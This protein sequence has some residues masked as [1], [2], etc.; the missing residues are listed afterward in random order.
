MAEGKLLILLGEECKRQKE[1]AKLDKE[2]EVEILFDVWSDTG[3][4]LGI[5]SASGKET[6]P[7]AAALRAALTR[8]EGAHL[9]PY[10][11]YSSK[12]VD[13]KPLF[14]HALEGSLGSIEIPEHE[15]RIYSA[16]LLGVKEIATDALKERIAAF[17]A[18]APKSDEPSKAPGADFRI[19]DVRAS[20]DA[21]LAKERTFSVIRIRVAAGSGTYMRGLAG[22]IGE[23]LGTSALALS[24]K[25]TKIGRH[26]GGLWLR[27]Y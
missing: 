19:N 17:L 7:D 11:A 24:I 18:K 20:W 21:A 26:M 1:Y 22:R 23:A 6:H 14:L 16:K 5:V 12:P 15:E 8:E 10:P 13:G 2:Y 4:A 9:R 25:R 3:D 27:S